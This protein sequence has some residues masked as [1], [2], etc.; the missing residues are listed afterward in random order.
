MQQAGS[1]PSPQIGNGASTE[2]C[3][4]RPAASL[5]PRVLLSS[6]NTFLEQKFFP[7]DET[8]FKV[9]PLLYIQ[10]AA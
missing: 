4:L 7:E 3:V 10:A 8:A 6:W 1:V 5:I 9:M 2:T